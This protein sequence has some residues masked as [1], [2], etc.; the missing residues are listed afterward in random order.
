MTYL[1]VVCRKD[2]IVGDPDFL[3]REVERHFKS[4]AERCPKAWFRI[5]WR[6]DSLVLDTNSL[7]LVSTWME[8]ERKFVDYLI[9]DF[10]IPQNKYDA[11]RE[12]HSPSAA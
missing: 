1:V 11:P 5:R 6:K 3:F 9:A 7:P 4:Y 8:T 10:H 12:C 2:R